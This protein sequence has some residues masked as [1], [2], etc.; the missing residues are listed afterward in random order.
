MVHIFIVEI[1]LFIYGINCTVVLLLKA[2]FKFIFHQ[3]LF[4]LGLSNVG[5]SLLLL[6]HHR[7]KL[8]EDLLLPDEGRFRQVL[9]LDHSKNDVVR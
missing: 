9:G 4:D 8:E 5:L 6:V 1:F 3:Y 2:L 7:T